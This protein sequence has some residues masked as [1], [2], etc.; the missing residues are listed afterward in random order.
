MKRE[1][2]KILQKTYDMIQ[3]GYVAL[4]QYPKSEKH[5]LA[6]ETKRSMYE[7]LKLTIRA[8]RRYYKKTTLQDI[9]IELDHLRYLIRLGHELGFLPFK[10]YEIWSK[11][12]DELGRMLGGWMKS[13]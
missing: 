7:L 9:D 2:L 12:L 1:D 3:Y 4:R 11:R 6:A 5:T 10:K 8:N 13:L